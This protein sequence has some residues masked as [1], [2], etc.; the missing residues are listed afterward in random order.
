MPR[1]RLAIDS[2]ADETFYGGAAGGGKSDALLG[3]ALDHWRTIIFRREYKWLR[4]LA[5]RGDEIF[6]GLGASHNRADEIFTLP[7]GRRVELVA[8]QYEHDA[9]GWQGQPHDLI[10]FD[11]LPQ[12]TEKMYR[13]ICAW[14]RSTRPGQRVRIACTGNPPKGKKD[15]VGGWVIRHWAPWLDPAYQGKRAESGEI[16]WFARIDDEDTEVDGPEPIEHNGEHIQPRSRTF[17]RSTIDDNPYLLESGYKSVLQNLPE[18]HRSWFLLGRFDLD[19]E[20]PNQTY[21]RFSD[22]NLCRVDYDRTKPVYLAMDFNLDPGTL[23]FSHEL[24]HG[25]YPAAD[26]CQGMRHLGAFGEIFLTGAEAVGAQRLAM[27][28]VSG[29][30]EGKRPEGWH[31]PENFA[32][33]INHPTHVWMRGDATGGARTAAHPDGASLWRQVH[34]V[35]RA[36]ITHY[37]AA[38][39]KANPP[40]SA[41][42]TAVNHWLC[43]WGLYEGDAGKHALHIDPRCVAL[44]ACLRGTQNA[45][46]GSGIRKS[47]KQ[48][49]PYQQMTHASDAWGYDVF[50]QMPL[51]LKTARPQHAERLAAALGF[52]SGASAQIPAIG[53]RPF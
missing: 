41:R 47:T 27:L 10:A 9:A 11:E 52:Q 19:L 32:G 44:I 43:S 12:F 17:I 48:G 7:D 15:P 23:I 46:D 6:G 2:P 3:L 4:A 37:H 29:E 51:K 31:L 53:S 30:D 24:H 34:A 26:E 5:D 13:L 28:A 39:A 25:E 22:A 35:M 36:N 40:V 21:W 45:T 50:A 16:R 18:P 33:L 8:L 1:Q 38:T 14:N 42:V 20:T 49:D